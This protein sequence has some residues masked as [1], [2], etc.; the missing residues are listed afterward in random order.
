M[1]DE[2]LGFLLFL[3][4]LAVIVK[5]D[6]VFT[7]LYLFIGA[8]LFGNYWTRRAITSV[9]FHR[10]FPSRVF[11]SEEIPIHLEVKNESVLPLIWLRIH[12]SLPVDL[13]IRRT[14]RRVVSLGPHG[15]SEFDYMLL[16]RKRGYYLIGPVFAYTGDFLG[17]V[18]DRQRE[19]GSDFLTVYPKII[20]LTGL[21]IPSQSPMG[22]L[23]HNQPIFEDPSRV[24][25]KRDYTVGDSLRRVDWK[26]SATL[27]RLQVKQFEPSI[28]LETAIFLN[29]HKDDYDIRTRFDIA[30]LAIVVAAS[31]ANWIIDK[32]QST[33]LYTNGF[34]PLIDGVIHDASTML[35]EPISPRK[36]GGHLM[37]IL[38]HLARVQIGDALPMVE[39]LRRSY[40]HLSW[41]T[42]LLLITSQVSEDLF[43]QLFQVQRAGLNLVL[44]KVGQDARTREIQQKAYLFNIPFYSI[45][46][47]R[48]LDIWRR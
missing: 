33:G 47:E 45:T 37:R 21:K 18:A 20:P 36:G 34:D 13:S 14:F 9:S 23:R 46:K 30:E 43:D 48:D 2:L 1:I 7:I 8:F 41:G 44:I 3:F 39:L 32:K 28:A 31:L 11:L 40:V 22:T 38:D 19:G 42:T 10:T 25:S 35:M 4:L 26:A 29:M 5:Q 6:F 16:A 24:L 17:L 15:K 12:E 27:G